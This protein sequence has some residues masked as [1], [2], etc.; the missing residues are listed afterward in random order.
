MQEPKFIKICMHLNF[1]GGYLTAFMYNQAFKHSKHVTILSHASISCQPQH[2]INIHD[3]T[4]EKPHKPD[5]TRLVTWLA[6][7]KDCDFCN[8]LK[9]YLKVRQRKK[10]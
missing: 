5:R 9:I 8:Q 7:I 6:M 10:E 1:F 2:K 3:D 4:T